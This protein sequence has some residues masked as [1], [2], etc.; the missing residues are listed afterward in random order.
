ME[1]ESEINKLAYSEGSGRKKLN[2]NHKIKVGN[3]N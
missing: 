2:E 1:R 3:R